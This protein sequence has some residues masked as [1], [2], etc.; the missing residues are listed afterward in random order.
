MPPWN[1]NMLKLV[2]CCRF[3]GCTYR[4]RPPFSRGI[5]VGEIEPFHGQQTRPT[6]NNKNS[7]NNSGGGNDNDND[8]TGTGTG[9]AS[10]TATT[11]ATFI[12][13]NRKAATAKAATAPAD[14]VEVQIR[15]P[16]YNEFLNPRI[17]FSVVFFGNNNITKSKLDL[18]VFSRLL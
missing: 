15:D 5:S 4:Q 17:R 13:Q 8:T 11:K 6:E 12:Q 14:G 1:V 10:A 16:W 18:I 9:T 3:H 2:A 7:N